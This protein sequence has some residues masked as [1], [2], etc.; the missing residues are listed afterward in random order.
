LQFFEFSSQSIE[1]KASIFT[2][3]RSFRKYG[4]FWWWWITGWW[5]FGV[6]AGWV[7][8]DWLFS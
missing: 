4:G 5:G 2:Q 7:G 3:L 1:Q 8:W 6:R